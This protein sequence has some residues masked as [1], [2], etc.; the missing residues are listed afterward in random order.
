MRIGIPAFLAASTTSSTLSGPPM[1]PGLM[2]TAATPASI[3]RSASEALKWMSAITGI[4][5]SRTIRARASASS[6]FGT[7]QRTISQPAEASAAIWA[8]VASTSCVFV[9]VIDWTTTG[10]P[11]PIVTSPTLI[12]R[13]EAIPSPSLASAEPVDVVRKPDEHE[14]QEER[15]SDR[16]DALVDLPADRA[17]AHALDDREQDVAA[18]ER[19]ERQEVQQCKRQADEA[20]HEQIPR[21]AD[22]DY[23][24]RDIHDP[25]R[26]RDL[27]AAGVRHYARQERRSGTRRMPVVFEAAQHRTAGPVLRCVPGGLEAEREPVADFLCSDRAEHLGGLA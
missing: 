7:A 13:S 10:A 1:L 15:D 17:A 5:D 20:E 23:L 11:P 18:V 4:G 6:I 21:E 25:G 14:H 24:L 3:A 22:G 8:V 12:C 2:R 16:G 9:S 27:L 26:P 19:Q